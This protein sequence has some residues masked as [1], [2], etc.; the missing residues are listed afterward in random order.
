MT[1]PSLGIML[2][3][4]HGIL[5]EE[6]IFTR[7]EVT[8]MSWSVYCRTFRPQSGLSSSQKWLVVMRHI[9]RVTRTLLLTSKL[10]VSLTDSGES[11]VL[12]KQIA[13]ACC[14]MSNKQYE[15]L[16]D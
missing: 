1:D 14:T 5:V 4:C 9:E 10:H 13:S 11:A 8:A 12:H 15:P 6:R 3:A 2:A 7:L 16:Q